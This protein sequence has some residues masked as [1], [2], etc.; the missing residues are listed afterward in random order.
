MHVPN[1][2]SESLTL[3]SD[4]TGK[5]PIHDNINHACTNKNEP[6]LVNTY[7][8]PMSNIV[9]TAHMDDFFSL[10]SSSSSTSFSDDEDLSYKLQK[11][12]KI[13]NNQKSTSSSSKII[14]KKSFV[15]KAISLA[16]KMIKISSRV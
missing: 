8:F 16:T 3:P 14:S 10:S 4:H 15:K 1:I 11:L 2:K 5:S 7:N 12:L 9:K 13:K 6:M